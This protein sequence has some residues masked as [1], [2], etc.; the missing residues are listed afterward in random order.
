MAALCPPVAAAAA[1]LYRNVAAGSNSSGV[2]L[3]LL[4][5]RDETVPIGI[6][7]LYSQ[8]TAAHILQL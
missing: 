6:R 2:H 8:Q 4:M 1:S 5:T 7:E 3:L